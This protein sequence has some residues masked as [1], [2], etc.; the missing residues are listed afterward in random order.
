MAA[1]AFLRRLDPPE[2]QEDH[3][4]SVTKNSQS[5]PETHSLSRPLRGRLPEI[6][7]C[8]ES[9]HCDLFNLTITP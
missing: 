8:Q 9:Y 4:I 1:A 3:H 6:S 5:P 2:E 7:Y